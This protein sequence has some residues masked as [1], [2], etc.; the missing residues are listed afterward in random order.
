MISLSELAKQLLTEKEVRIVYHIRPD[1][2]CIGSAYALALAL[3]SAGIHADVAGRDPVPNTFRYLTDQFVPDDLQDPVWIS[4]DTSTPYRTGPYEQ[5][6]F[7][8]C[9]DHHNRNTVQA[10]YKYVEADCGACGEIICKLLT[11]MQIPF[12]KLIMNLIY[13]AIVTDTL[14]FRTSDTNAQTFRIAAEL[15]EKGADIEKIGK[16]HM[17]YKSKGRRMIEDIM[18]KEMQI[19]CDNQLFTSMILLRDLESAGI[20][21]SDLEG[22]NSFL[23][24]YEE[25]RI[26]VTFR[27]LPDGR[28]R[29]SVHT[30]GAVSAHEI[31]QHFGGGGHLH[32]S[33]CE[34]DEPPLQARPIMEQFCM[35]Y[36][37]AHP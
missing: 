32:A 37:K 27:E 19:L 33:G 4:V 8:Y 28:T 15:A 13:T 9:I 24:Q 21:D 5:Q 6:H 7:T 17:L 26:G 2:D 30:K 16:R 14:C 22:I 18:R 3:Q 36:L 29:C 31:C 12:T 20:A 34:M 35:E 23:E 11:E 25:M 1:G 10:D